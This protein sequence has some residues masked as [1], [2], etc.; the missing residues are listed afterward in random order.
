MSTNTL[1]GTAYSY[2]RFSTKK[3]ERGDSIRRQIEARDLWLKQHPLVTLAPDGAYE[4]LGTS[5]F[6]GK[7]RLDDKTALKQFINA[8]E[9]GR[10]KPGAFLIV[11]SFDRLTREEFGEAAEFVLGLVNRGIRIVQLSP[12]EVI[13]EKP[14]DLTKALILVVELT[15][16]HGESK[17]K[18]DTVSAVWEA[19][20]K[21]CRATKKPFTTRCPSWI[22]FRDG[23]FQFKDGAKSLVRRIF[24]LSAA[25]HGCRAV[26]ATLD[27]EK[28]PTWEPRTVRWHDA[29]IRRIVRGREALGEYQPKVFGLDG[30]R[31][32]EGAPIVGYYPAAVSEAEWLAA[33][34]ARAGR[35]R[36]GGR[37]TKDATL[38]NVFAGLLFEGISGDRITTV[39]RHKGKALVTSGFRR[40]GDG[41]SSFPLVPFERAIL[42]RLRE[43]EPGDVLG[44]GDGPDE[45][46][47]L[48]A[49]LARV[50]SVLRS[51]A[52]QFDDGG[53]EIPAIAAKVK[54]KNAERKELATGLEAAESRAASPLSA[55]WGEAQGILGVLD[56][57]PP[58][59]LTEVRL[60]LKGVLAR[61]IQ[62]ITCVFGGSTRLRWGAV[63]VQFATGDSHRDYLI[64]H[65]IKNGRSERPESTEVTS[66][67]DATSSTDDF[68]L[69][70]PAD[71]QEVETL[72]SAREWY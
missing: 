11:E 16:G 34:T 61:I 31:K 32:I 68:D 48:K 9:S 55:V 62:S 26:A 21:E 25:G 72:L 2:L 71:A 14:V 23:K 36:R 40:R 41:G 27:R 42:S 52:D 12:V 22:E 50:D 38:T 53:D 59:R 33:K 30:R 44:T 24:A 60:K 17:R 43:L 39:N 15:R 64:V 45:V 5:S 46:A 37:P 57:A 63:R 54:A 18:M 6:R 51:L 49:K 69:R 67:A 13:L 66:F 56:G 58:A 70:N 28:V 4:E 35:H 29:L 19:K 1:S 7:H 8:V 10:V 3:Q 65:R 20:R 47:E